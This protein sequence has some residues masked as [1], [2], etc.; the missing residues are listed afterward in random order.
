MFSQRFTLLLFAFLIIPYVLTVKYRIEP[1][2][3]L[4]LPSGAG[5]VAVGGKQM[6]VSYTE[7]YA[8]KADGTMSKVDAVRMFAPVPIHYHSYILLRNFGMI[9]KEVSPKFGAFSPF[10]KELNI[11]KNTSEQEKQ[12]VKK[13]LGQ[14][15][16]EQGFTA[17]VLQ[18]VQV[19]EVLALP[20]GETI[21]KNSSYV[22]TLYLD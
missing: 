18:V 16:I 5:K 8:L 22:T 21:A 6:K 7:Y 15:L 19:E 9:D 17:A 20:A 2:P 10:V 4:I 13:W 11:L 1:Y 14:K 3:A 12:E